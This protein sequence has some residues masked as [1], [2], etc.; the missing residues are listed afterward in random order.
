MQKSII[1]KGLDVFIDKKQ[2]LNHIYLE[3]RSGS[4]V[5]LLGPS[6]SGKTTL[7]RTLVGRLRA[8]TGTVEVLGQKA[9]TP[10]L[11]RNVGYMSQHSAVYPDLNVL[12]NIAY[13]ARLLDCPTSE[14]DRVIKVVDLESK[15]KQQFSSLSGGEKARVSLAIALLGTPKLLILDEPTV[16]LD[17]VL[18]N[19]L[20]QM[21]R[22]IANQ[23][24]TIL[25]S[26][27]VMDEA[28]RCDS[29]ILIRNGA[30]LANGTP[31]ELKKQT[32]K[33][34]IEASFLYLVA[35]ETH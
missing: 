23:G 30:L 25:V 7:M 11:R 10:G 34:N 27:H 28:E 29:L 1:I 5:G 12:A 3:V 24:V 31:S 18:R 4:I 20:W 26:S 8:T 21:F 15:K 22:D 16:G 13:F 6:G 35:K 19:R 17:P 33:K 2:I 32:G 9:G 14:V